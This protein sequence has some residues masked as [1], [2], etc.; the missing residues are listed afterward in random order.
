MNQEELFDQLQNYF[1]EAK[2]NVEY[3]SECMITPEN[4]IIFLL[5][6]IND[7]NYGVGSLIKLLP[8]EIREIDHTGEPSLKWS[9]EAVGIKEMG[10]FDIEVFTRKMLLEDLG[11]HQI[12]L[13]SQSLNFDMELP[14]D[15]DMT[16]P[17]QREVAGIIIS[18]ISEQQLDTQE[19]EDTANYLAAIKRVAEFLETWW[20]SNYDGN[21]RKT[22]DAMIKSA[23][24]DWINWDEDNKQHRTWDKYGEFLPE[25]DG[26]VNYEIMTSSDKKWS[27][28]EVY[29]KPKYTWEELNKNLFESFTEVMAAIARDIEEQNS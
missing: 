19:L 20:G 10:I 29:N 2:G 7:D 28:M 27:F 24:G 4:P 8:G 13:P 25:D 22:W 1:T 6:S 15:L 11:M 12:Q 5:V 26:N 3:L 16:N 21:Q 9:A 14:S 18:Y 17:V 23:L